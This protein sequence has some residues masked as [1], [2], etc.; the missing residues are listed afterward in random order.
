MHSKILKRL[1]FLASDDV[2]KH[3]LNQ[4]GSSYPRAYITYSVGRSWGI[5]QN[6]GLSIPQKGL[7]H[8]YN[9]EQWANRHTQYALVS[10]WDCFGGRL[11]TTYAVLACLGPNRQDYTS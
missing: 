2:V 11:A 3:I 9:G 6:P 7:D 8:D 1:T 10:G 4:M 5:C